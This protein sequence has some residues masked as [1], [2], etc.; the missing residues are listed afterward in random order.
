MS[1]KISNQTQ[2]HL[3]RAMEVETIQKNGASPKNHKGLGIFFICIAV[4]CS[5]TLGLFAQ[6]IIIKKD[7]TEIQAKV[8]EIGINE[9]KYTRFGMTS[10]TYSLLKSDIFMI[11]YENGTKD[12]FN[13]ENV[14]SQANIQQPADGSQTMNPNLPKYKYTFG[15]TIKPVGGEKSPFLAGFL[16]F[17]IP[18]VGQFYNGDIGGGFL[19]LGCNIGCNLIW[20][21]SYESDYYGN[22]S[23]NS[24]L[25]TVGLI[26]ALIINVCSIVS[27]SQGAHKVNKARGFELGHNIYLKTEPTLL[28]I[29]D[30]A[31]Q[32]FNNSA[33]GM[34]VSLTF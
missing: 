8:T 24:E 16:S 17:L 14:Q 3:V 33:Y 9:V 27:A 23:V 28:K 34:S 13:V 12:I 21:N 31:Q 29:D 1:Q 2:P 4:F 26:S 7:G 19:F 30:F 5:S 32:S 20:M 10:P 25:F 11:K 15:N 22:V 6:D 18:G